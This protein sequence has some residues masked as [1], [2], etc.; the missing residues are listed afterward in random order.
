MFTVGPALLAGS[1]S[2]PYWSSV[3]SL[4]YF[5][6][7]NGSTTFTDQ[8]PS[9]PWTST[10]GASISTAQFKFGTSSGSFVHSSSQYIQTPYKSGFTWGSNNF[11]MEAFV[12]PT[13]SFDSS[14]ISQRNTGTNGFSLECRATGAVWFRANINGTYSDTR[15]TT[16]TGVLTANVWTHIALVRNGTSW[17]I[18]V[19][20]VSSGTLTS[21][22]VLDNNSN[23]PV[24]IGQAMS[25][26]EDN[27]DG[28]IG[29]LRLTNG[30]AR[31]TSNF[32]PPTLQFPN[33]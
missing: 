20:G 27:F 12:R 29:E 33:H 24:R 30:V 1:I 21:S 6:G 28:Y 23:A 11:T 16:S 25:G 15:I 10:N 26:T 19:G 22:G 13:L 5:N 8:V 14:F 4:L 3:V 32:T 2:D 18:Y 9:T 17:V 31:Y 7:T